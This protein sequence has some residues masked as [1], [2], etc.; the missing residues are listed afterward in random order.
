MISTRKITKYKA[1]P[2]VFYYH[3]YKCYYTLIYESN[4]FNM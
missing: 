2:R 3:N 1:H 4:E